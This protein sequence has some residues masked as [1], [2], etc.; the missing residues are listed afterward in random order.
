[1]STPKTNR[2]PGGFTLIELILV[3]AIL[4]IVMSFALP[5]INGMS[6]RARLKSIAET[7]TQDI[8]LA[9]SEAVLNNSAIVVSVVEG[10]NWCYGID[11][12][13]CNCNT[14][15]DCATKEIRS[16]EF[17]G[18]IMDTDGTDVSTL[19]FSPTGIT[20]GDGSSIMFDKSGMKALL[21]INPIGH[22]SACSNDIPSLA[23]C[24]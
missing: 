10:A 11:T 17:S 8:Q 9:R 5:S 14:A 6:N 16:S 13:A 4:G 3:I 12:T 19:T 24:P 18:L 20:T 15:G 23:N 1:M 2:P 22:I 7:M 21:T